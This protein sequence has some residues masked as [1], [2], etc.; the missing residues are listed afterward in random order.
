MKTSRWRNFLIGAGSIFS[1][2]PTP[3]RLPLSDA[4]AARLNEKAL[5]DDWGAVG[6]DMRK[7]MRALEEKK[8]AEGKQ[9]S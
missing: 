1:L 4:E 8:Q 5:G 6:G 2:A 9:S 7:A 3:P